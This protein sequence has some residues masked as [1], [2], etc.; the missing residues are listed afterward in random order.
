MVY[1]N[2]ENVANTSRTYY[3]D[4]EINASTNYVYQIAGYDNSGNIGYL[5]SGLIVTT[6]PPDETAPD[7]Y[8][9]QVI[10]ATTT[11][12]IVYWETD[13]NS[14]SAVYYGRTSPTDYRQVSGSH[15]NHTVTLSSLDESATYQYIVSSCDASGNC[16]NSS[17]F[18]FVAGGDNSPPS[19]SVD[20]PETYNANVMPINGTTDALARIIIYLNGDLTP[21]RVVQ[22]DMSGDFSPI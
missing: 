16:R 13:E 14:D 3:T 8:N 11:S 18:S 6:L 22:A 15:V 20:V 9:I 1:R 4:D 12:V 17:Q 2:G 19:L 21:K 5:S 7:L 10:G